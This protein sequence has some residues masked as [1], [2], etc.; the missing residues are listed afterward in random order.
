MLWLLLF[1]LLLAAV[2]A[3][4]LVLRPAAH[5]MRH[6]LL[7]GQSVFAFEGGR[8]LWHHSLPTFKTSLPTMLLVEEH[9]YVAAGSIYALDKETGRQLWQ[10]QIPLVTALFTQEQLATSLFWKEGHLYVETD[11]QRLLR[12]DPQTGTILWEYA[13][14]EAEISPPAFSERGDVIYVVT[15]QQIG[16]SAYEVTALSVKKCLLLWQQRFVL[17]AHWDHVQ[18]PIVQEEL[19]LVPLGD[20]VMVL[21]TTD[22]HRLAT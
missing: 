15:R 5:P 16:T 4:L 8:T 18:A 9:L 14:A 20:V 19:L 1:L 13:E 17:P 10:R 21:R 6:Y 3:G 11:A 7:T 2:S 12:L 22:G